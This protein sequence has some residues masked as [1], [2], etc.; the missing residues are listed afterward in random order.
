MRRS[1]LL[2]MTVGIL[3]LLIVTTTSA[4]ARGRRFDGYGGGISVYT[5]NVAISSGGFAGFGRYGSPPGVSVRIG[6]GRGWHRR[7]YSPGRYGRHADPLYWRGYGHPAGGVS[8]ALYGT[9]GGVGYVSLGRGRAYGARPVS[10]FRGYRPFTPY[11]PSVTVT[12]PVGSSLPYMTRTWVPG[13]LSEWGY[14]RGHWVI[15]PIRPVR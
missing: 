11:G 6:A 8:I 2:L 12:V 10:R 4:G 3:S 13:R 7:A 9:G 1:A 14:S 15:Q 5:G